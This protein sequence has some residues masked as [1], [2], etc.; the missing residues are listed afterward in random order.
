MIKQNKMHH[1]ILVDN[2]GFKFIK[3]LNYFI[4]YI[5]KKVL[6]QK[7]YI[8]IVNMIKIINILMLDLLAHY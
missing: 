5:M 7:N 1:F 6:R 2:L 8:H 4:L 3:I